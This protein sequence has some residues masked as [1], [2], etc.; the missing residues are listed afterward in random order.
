MGLAILV[1][2][3]TLDAAAAQVPYLQLVPGSTRV[4]G[5]VRAFGTDFCGTANC[6]P[7]TLIAKD[8]FSGNAGTVLT[9]G[10]GVGPDGHFEAAFT[11]DLQPGRYTVTATQTTADGTP[12]SASTSLLVQVPADTTTTAPA[13]STTG[14]DSTVSSSGA[15]ASSSSTTSPSST[16]S[17]TPDGTAGSAQPAGGST[18]TH[19]N[20]RGLWPWILA[21]LL[22]A[23]AVA[24]GTYARNRRGFHGGFFSRREGGV[25]GTNEEGPA[26]DPGAGGAPGP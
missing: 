25:E 16:S 2:T 26:G 21:G 9:E 4:G 18:R 6:S 20:D 23:G 17:S 13:P 10:V 1:S 12:L 3:T 8:D 22:L 19:D 15:T 5:Q 14:G 7:V 24:A 11:A